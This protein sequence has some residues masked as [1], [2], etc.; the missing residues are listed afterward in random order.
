MRLAH[1]SDI[2]IF[3]DSFPTLRSMLNKR[4]IGGLNWLFHRR[5]QH[6]ARLFESMCQDIRDQNPDHVAITG[7]LSNLSLLSEFQRTHQCLQSLNLP[8]ERL[9][10]IP[11]NHD[12]YVKQA[13]T[14]NLF[15][16][17]FRS[18]SAHDFES[19]PF[20]HIQGDVV[21]IG[22]ST[23]VP[24]PPFLAYGRIDPRQLTRLGEI[25]HEQRARFRVVLIHHAPVLYRN[26][27][28][29]GLRD[30]AV[31]QEMLLKQGCELILHGHEHRDLF[32]SIPGPNGPIPV[33]GVGSGTYAD[34][35]MDRRARYHV[36][37]LSSPSGSIWVETR[38]HD[39]DRNQFVAYS[40][41]SLPVPWN[42]QDRQRVF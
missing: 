34:P 20:V 13:V 27:A 12:A 1:L 15:F 25:L 42:T 36:Y 35:R 40:K 11:G 18:S 7:D 23:A 30:K 4:L 3:G 9:S 37:D 8:K 5:H 38:V 28:L 14:Q 17:F 24:C 32:A 33:V 21:L 6:D 31:L 39:P 29:H 41:R 2:H 26:D 16:H 10:I 19:F 22:V